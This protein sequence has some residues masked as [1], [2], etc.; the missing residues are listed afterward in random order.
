[1]IEA[2]D[3]DNPEGDGIN[4]SREDQELL[5]NR[6]TDLYYNI[7]KNTERNRNRLPLSTMLKN[8]TSRDNLLSYLALIQYNLEDLQSRAYV[9][10]IFSHHYRNAEFR[11]GDYQDELD[12]D[13]FGNLLGIMYNPHYLEILD[14]IKRKN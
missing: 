6:L 13:P 4:D 14:L 9:I 10:C 7:I 12:V 5:G 1:M 3:T 11:I 8:E 2:T